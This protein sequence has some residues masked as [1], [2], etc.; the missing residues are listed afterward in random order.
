MVYADS[1]WGQVK[2]NTHD[3][4]IIVAATTTGTYQWWEPIV[5]SVPDMLQGVVYA[6]TI[7]YVVMRATNE[8]IKFWKSQNE[9]KNEE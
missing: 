3:V 6:G 4:G 1:H 7:I 9:R 8:V 5:A 2:M